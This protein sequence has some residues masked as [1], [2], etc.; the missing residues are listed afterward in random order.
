MMKIFANRYF[1]S[2]KKTQLYDLHVAR[3]GKIV[4]FAGTS[5]LTLRISD[6]CS[7][8]NWYY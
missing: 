1:L 2:V 3:K 5:T 4:E 7:I 6:A 8:P